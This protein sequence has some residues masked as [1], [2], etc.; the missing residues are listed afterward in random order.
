MPPN[1]AWHCTCDGVQGGDGKHDDGGQV[2]VPAQ[3]DVHK[4][5]P[6]VQVDLGW[7]RQIEARTAAGTGGLKEGPSQGHRLARSAGQ[8][9]WPPLTQDP[10]WG[11]LCDLTPNS[12]LANYPCHFLLLLPQV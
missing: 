3:A 10:L 4:Q 6:R 7:E 9:P 12:P 2:E 11:L 8:S 1:R 5:S